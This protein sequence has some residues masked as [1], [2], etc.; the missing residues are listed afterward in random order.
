MKIY[1]IY[2][3]LLNLLKDDNLFLIIIFYL[4]KDFIKFTFY[5]ICYNL[6]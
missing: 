4:V 3:F 5:K 1:I 2:V 6:I